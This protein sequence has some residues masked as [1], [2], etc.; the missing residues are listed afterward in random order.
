MPYW[1]LNREKIRRIGKDH[2]N[3]ILAH[4]HEQVE[5]GCPEKA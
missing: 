2:V 3:A 1:G 4:P 5:P